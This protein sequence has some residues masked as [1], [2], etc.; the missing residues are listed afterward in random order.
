[1]GHCL[2]EMAC[3]HWNKNTSH[4][5]KDRFSRENKFKKGQRRLFSGLF[6]EKE[7]KYLDKSEQF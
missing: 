7:F 6:H 5:S 2:E 4:F 3:T 1:M